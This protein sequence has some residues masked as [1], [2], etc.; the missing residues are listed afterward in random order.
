MD[1]YMAHSLYS[2]LYNDASVTSQGT[3][4]ELDYAIQDKINDIVTKCND[5]FTSDKEF[6]PLDVVQYIH[7]CL[8]NDNTSLRY[9]TGIQQYITM[10]CLQLFS[11]YKMDKIQ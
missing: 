1:H 2:H 10:K 3:S 8:N 6:T 11:N 4:L 7:N 9:D 5:C